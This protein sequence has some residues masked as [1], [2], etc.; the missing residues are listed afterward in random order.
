ML[1][2][3]IAPLGSSSE[4]QNSFRTH[5][6]WLARTSY[7]LEGLKV[8]LTHTTPH[9]AYPPQQGSQMTS[10]GE[11]QSLTARGRVSLGGIYSTEDPSFL[12]MCYSSFFPVNIWGVFIGSQLSSVIPHMVQQHRLHQA[13]GLA[14]CRVHKNRSSGKR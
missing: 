10:P 3:S 1:S 4:Q 12:I 7:R 2:T 9:R 6:T 11:V 8:S 14:V 13:L 5:S